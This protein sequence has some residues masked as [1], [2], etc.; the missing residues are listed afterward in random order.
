MGLPVSPSKN[1]SGCPKSDMDVSFPAA[2]LSDDQRKSLWDQQGG[3]IFPIRVS[4]HAAGRGS[5]Q[6]FTIRRLSD[7]LPTL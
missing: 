3:F 7:G 5:K 2:T 1:K 4:L 6:F